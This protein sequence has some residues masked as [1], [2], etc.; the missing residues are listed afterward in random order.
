MEYNEVNHCENNTI[1]EHRRWEFNFWNKEGNYDTNTVMECTL[2]DIVQVPTNLLFL[3]ELDTKILQFLHCHP[4][5][6][7][8]IRIWMDA[9]I[10]KSIII[11]FCIINDDFFGCCHDG[12][13]CCLCFPCA[14]H[15]LHLFEI[16]QA[17]NSLCK[18]L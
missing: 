2:S 9:F 17:S 7:S 6:I 5:C 12:W 16:M 18:H 10:C 3:C 13:Y 11:K 8:I 14:K 4:H 15:A 1:S